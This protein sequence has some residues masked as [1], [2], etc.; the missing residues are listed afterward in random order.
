MRNSS[1]RANLQFKQAAAMLAIGVAVASSAGTT[2]AV[3]ADPVQEAHDTYCIACHDTSVYTRDD[4]LAGDYDALR[5]QVDRW[6]STISLSWSNEEIDRMAAWL[7][8]RYY[9]M[10]C[11][12][13]C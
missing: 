8:T 6:Q 11:P 4:R 2:D 7:A 9:P 10:R 12:D 3:A 5:A 13:Q 1:V